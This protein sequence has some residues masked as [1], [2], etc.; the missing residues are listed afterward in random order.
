MS[1]AQAQRRCAV[2]I[3]GFEPP[4]TRRRTTWTQTFNI[5]WTGS[6]K[7]HPASRIG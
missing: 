1:K 4:V 6:K 7:L 5:E 2:T 3:D